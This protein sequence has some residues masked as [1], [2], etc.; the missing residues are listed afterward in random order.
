[1]ETLRLAM[2]RPYLGRSHPRFTCYGLAKADN[3][4]LK[5]FDR[6]IAYTRK[7]LLSLR[8]RVVTGRISFGAYCSRKW[9]RKMCR[10]FDYLVGK[11]NV[12][13]IGS[14]PLLDVGHGY[15]LLAIL[16]MACSLIIFYND[17]DY[18]DLSDEE[19][20]LVKFPLSRWSRSVITKVTVADDDIIYLFELH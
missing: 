5:D 10:Q 1:M 19:I 11:A 16:E 9:F 20:E 18:R 3:P 17:D 6:H 4:L 13:R 2:Y 7:K 14:D 15:V 12:F 8:I